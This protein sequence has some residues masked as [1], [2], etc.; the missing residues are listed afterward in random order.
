MQL[1]T[2]GMG[3]IGL[4][5]AR[6]FLD[7]G[8]EVVL[9][10]YRNVR[11]PAFLEG[12][13]GKRVLVEPVDLTAPHAVIDLVRKYDF[14]GVVHLAA[15]PV[16]IWS[17]AEEYR[18]NMVGL[19]NVLEAARLAEVARVAV[20]SSGTIYHDLAAGPFTE[21]M[22]LPM[23]SGSSTP[24]FKKS[25]EILAGHYADRTGQEIVF[26]RLNGV[27]GTA[28]Q[29]MV[30]LP[31]RLVHAAVQGVPGP[32]KGRMPNPKIGD[33]IGSGHV[34]D[35]ARAI[36]IL[37]ARPKLNHRVYNIAGGEL[38]HC[39]DFVD[40]VLNAVPE[41]EI[42]LEQGRG[43]NYKE[44]AY[45]DISRIRDETGFAPEVSVESGVAEYVEWLRAGNQ[46]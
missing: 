35:C 12:E 43:D 22:L 11:E 6:A 21:D 29:S 17:A 16:G 36:Q 31:S 14:A 7:A 19:V 18:A 9:T 20:G 34:K 46:R 44:Y 27:W 25:F 2:G 30:N 38:V 24:A 32:L 37:M 23:N 15:P 33:A 42:S 4:H 1:I 3:F 8:E 26:L 13:F 40:A 5:T 45:L 10:R 28:Y 39:E 41:A